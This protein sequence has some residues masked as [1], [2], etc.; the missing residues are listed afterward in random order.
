MKNSL[1]FCGDLQAELV[2]VLAGHHLQP[3]GQSPLVNAH[4][5]MGG[6]Q[7]EDVEEQHVVNPRYVQ[8]RRVEAEGAGVEGGHDQDT[9]VA[10]QL[11]WMEF[12]RVYI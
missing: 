2:L 10:K 6:G 11:L 7:A 4:G 12:N 1:Q 9:A 5:H 3:N 8:Q